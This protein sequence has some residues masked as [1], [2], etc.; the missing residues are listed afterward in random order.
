[1]ANGTMNGERCVLGKLYTVGPDV[2]H[3]DKQILIQ[4]CN[5]NIKYSNRP[6]VV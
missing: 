2:E 1:M 5:R 3:T 6:E 4:Y